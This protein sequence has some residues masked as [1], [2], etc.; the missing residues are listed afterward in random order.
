M[1]R[2]MDQQAA[3]RAFRDNL[4]DKTPSFAF[5]DLPTLTFPIGPKSVS[6]ADWQS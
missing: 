1:A 6:S 2:T 3:K 4:D 5:E